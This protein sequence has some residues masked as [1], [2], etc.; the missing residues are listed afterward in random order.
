V[1]CHRVNFTFYWARLS[2][3]GWVV[4]SSKTRQRCLLYSEQSTIENHSV[5]YRLLMTIKHPLVSDHSEVKIYQKSFYTLILPKLISWAYQTQTEHD[6]K[7]PLWLHHTS[8]WKFSNT[9]HNSAQRCQF[10]SSISWTAAAYQHRKCN[11]QTRLLKIHFVMLHSLSTRLQSSMSSATVTCIQ[12]LIKST[13]HIL[14]LI[15]IIIK[16][17]QTELL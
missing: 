14:I 11:Q 8:F 9:W 5:W 16:V 12:L 1:A 15:G 3:A 10:F 2:T 4:V 13:W 6:A 17:P 7:H